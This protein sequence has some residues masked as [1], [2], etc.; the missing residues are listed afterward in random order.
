M[1]LPR[2][3]RLIFPDLKG[4]WGYVNLAQEAAKVKESSSNPL[5][6]PEACRLWKNSIHRRLGVNFSYEKLSGTA[7]LLLFSFNEG[8]D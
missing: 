4:T 8:A 2:M 5:L 1:T 6:D 7:D 3:C